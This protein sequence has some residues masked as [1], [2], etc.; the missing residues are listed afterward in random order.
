MWADKT[1]LALIVLGAL[2]GCGGPGVAAEPAQASV[3]VRPAPPASPGPQRISRLG[4]R[5]VIAVLSA[6]F[7]AFL[8]RVEVERSPAAGR[9][10]GWK[11]VAL[12]G[13]PSSWAGID[14]LPGDVVTQVNARPIERPEQALA[15]FQGLSIARS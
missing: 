7:G 1:P 13:D 15:C 11:I 8:G 9:F 4:R 14:L 3:A 6:G 10:V 2:A 5:D 12:K